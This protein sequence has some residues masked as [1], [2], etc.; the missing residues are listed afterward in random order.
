MEKSPAA[1][2]MPEFLDCQAQD[3]QNTIFILSSYDFF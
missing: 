2:D 1:L 3:C